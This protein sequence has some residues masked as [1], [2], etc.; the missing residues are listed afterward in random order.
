METGSQRDKIKCYLW[1][2]HLK[3]QSWDGP[4][5]FSEQA[6]FFFFFWAL[7]RCQG[8]WDLLRG[9]IEQKWI[10][11]TD[12]SWGMTMWQALFSVLRKLVLWS[13]PWMG[14]E[15]QIPKKINTREWKNKDMI[16]C[17]YS[18]DHYISWFLLWHTFGKG[19]SQ[20]PELGFT[21]KCWLGMTSLPRVPESGP[22]FVSCSAHVSTPRSHFLSLGKKAN[23]GDNL[24]AA[25]CQ[26]CIDL[27]CSAL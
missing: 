1:N 21:C 6:H 3:L 11:S 19:L 24:S 25:L 5:I 26:L 7:N 10:H 17:K 4:Y 16:I 14:E 12:F 8:W 23:V 27:V 9:L 20:S 18:R 2:W 22:S 13:L 15:M